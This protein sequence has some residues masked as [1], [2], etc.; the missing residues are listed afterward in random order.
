MIFTLL[1]VIQATAYGILKNKSKTN[2]HKWF[3]KSLILRNKDYI[4]LLIG[5]I[6]CNFLIWK[7]LIL[8]IKQ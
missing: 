8:R 3:V 6:D 4:G 5:E 1:A 2:S 7:K